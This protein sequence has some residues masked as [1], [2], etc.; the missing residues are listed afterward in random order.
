MRRCATHSVTS[1]G[2]T[3]GIPGCRYEKGGLGP[4]FSYLMTWVIISARSLS[5]KGLVI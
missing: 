5:L 1:G 4:P 3:D 2:A